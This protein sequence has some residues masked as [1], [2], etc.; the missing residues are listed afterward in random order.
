MRLCRHPAHMTRCS[1]AYSKPPAREAPGPVDLDDHVRASPLNDQ[2]EQVAFGQPH[3]LARHQAQRVQRVPHLPVQPGAGRGARGKGSQEAGAELGAGQ[4]VGHAQLLLAPHDP[5]VKLEQRAVIEP[6]SALVAPARK[7]RVEKCHRGWHVVSGRVGPCH[8]GQLLR[9]E[10]GQPA[11]RRLRQGVE[12][13]RRPLAS[14]GKSPC[15]IGELLR[16]ELVHAWRRF[17]GDSVEEGR[18]WTAD[19]R[20]GPGGVGQ[21]LCGEE[22]ADEDGGSR[23]HRIEQDGGRMVGGGEGP[24]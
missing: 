24:G 9:L 5:L 16:L 10:E 18:R 17:G 22:L 15:Q 21:A 4:A 13:L 6:W 3:S 1:S 11:C 12:E 23:G 19:S 7:G 8:V 2:V 20:E 14:S